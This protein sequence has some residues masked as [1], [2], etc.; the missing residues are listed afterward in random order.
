MRGANL[1]VGPLVTGFLLLAVAVGFGGCSGDAVPGV[2]PAH[3]RETSATEAETETTPTVRPGT[4]CAAAGVV[5]TVLGMP[6]VSLNNGATG[7]AARFG[8]HF[9]TGVAVAADGTVYVTDESNHRVVALDAAGQVT[10]IVGT[11]FVGDSQGGPLATAPLH[12]PTALAWVAGTASV[13]PGALIVALRGT[14]KIVKA[15]LVAGQLSVLGGTGE[16]GYDGDGPAREHMLGAPR[17]VAVGPDGSI[18]LADTDNH[19]I[20]VIRPDGALET[21]AGTPSVPGHAG[22]GGPAKDAAL[23]TPVGLALVGGDLVFADSGSQT[24][25]KIAL[26]TGTMTL[27]AGGVDQPGF[28]DGTAADARFH[29]PTGVAAHDGAILVTEEYNHCVRRVDLATGAV[30]RYAGTCGTSGFGGDLGPREDALLS[31]PMGVATSAAGDVYV[32]DTA[33]QVVRAIH[34]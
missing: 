2:E 14:N 6:G 20:R 1:L 34:R 5:C 31:S 8:L 4:G 30:S 7:A 25:R 24:I 3:D 23:H 19:L 12:G 29:Y 33:N 21:L 27:V 15:D 13:A 11:G 26:A 10:T 9:P 32:A 16:R 17:G 18:Y 22:D 28:A